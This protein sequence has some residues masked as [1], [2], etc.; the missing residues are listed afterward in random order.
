[1]I[2]V[3]AQSMGNALAMEACLRRGRELGVTS[4]VHMGGA[5][6][7]AQPLECWKRLVDFDVVLR[8]SMDTLACGEAWDVWSARVHTALAQRAVRSLGRE[9]CSRIRSWP[10]QA[11]HG[12][13]G[14]A[15]TEADGAERAEVAQGDRYQAAIRVGGVWRPAQDEA[16]S[17]DDADAVWPGWVSSHAEIGVAH[18]ATLDGRRVQ[19]RRVHYDGERYLEAMTAVVEVSYS[20]LLRDM[21]R[22]NR[23]P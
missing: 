22:R 6:W 7:G 12:G 8:N 15:T 23:P 1:M 11:E 10:A 3:M 16:V 9:R 17:L 21:A 19:F 4:A 14:F 5:V 2:L 20:D 13:I 18:F